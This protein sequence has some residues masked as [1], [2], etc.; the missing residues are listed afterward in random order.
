MRRT[1]LIS[2]PLVV[3]SLDQIKKMGHAGLMSCAVRPNKVGLYN[4][5]TPCFVSGPCVQAYKLNN[6]LS[7]AQ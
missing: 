3:W 6:Q 5:V 4:N 1:W 2:K 7:W